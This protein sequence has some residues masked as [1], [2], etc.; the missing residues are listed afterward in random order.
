MK[1][2]MQE[3]ENK[4]KQYF[5]NFD[6]LNKRRVEWNTATKKQI[7]DTLTSINDNFKNLVWHVARN[8]QIKNLE[9]VYWSMGNE[10]AGFSIGNKL[11]VRRPGY[12]NFAQLA[13]GKIIVMVSYPTI[14]ENIREEIKPKI[15]GE[16]L[17]SEINEDLIIS[18]AENFLDEI[19][20]WT[21]NL[22]K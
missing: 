1:A 2:K 19:N 21:M 18:L 15:L 10:M 7:H 8:E 11:V 17:P 16:Y 3:L 20:D 5:A 12:L 22:D 14:E 6:E 13:N 9:S 4:V